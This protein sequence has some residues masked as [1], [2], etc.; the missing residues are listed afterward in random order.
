[1]LI[2][3]LKML[4]APLLVYGALL[5][6]AAQAQGGAAANAEIP[7]TTSQMADGGQ[8]AQPITRNYSLMWFVVPVVVIASYGISR[9]K[10]GPTPKGQIQSDRDSRRDRQHPAA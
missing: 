1:M 2:Q 6:P 4:I 7:L 5:L 10:R 3:N 9:R 8:P